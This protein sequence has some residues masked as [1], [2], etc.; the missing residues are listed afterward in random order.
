MIGDNKKHNITREDLLPTSR[1]NIWHKIIGV[2]RRK[3]PVIVLH[4]G[5]AAS[6]YY[7]EP[8]EALAEDR[9]VIFYDQL[10]CGK[11]DR[12]NDRA[13]WTIDYYVQEL[14]QIKK[15]LDLEKMHIIGHSWGTM[16]AVDYALSGQSGIS[17]LVLS[18]PCLS[19]K[20]WKIDQRKYIL[21]LPE[22]SRKIIE[23]TE[24]IGNFDSKEYQDV[25]MEYYKFHLCRLDVWPECLN[26]SF[27]EMNYGIY[28]YMWGA[29][30]FTVT[31]TLKNYDRTNDLGKIKAP[32]L[33]TCGEYDESSPQTCECYRKKIPG[34]ELIIF[35]DASHN[36]HLEKTQD[37]IKAV[38]D[39]LNR[40]DSY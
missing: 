24:R 4:G 14:S 3:T 22:E 20:M 36:H 1:G 32:V 27:N 30:E 16:I 15:I 34:S 37:Y 10:G 28:K 7:L 11:S 8:L 9:P 35:K 19:S 5:P 18:S 31:G 13:I 6:H 12:T 29:S 40:I 21:D 25:I 26:K 39:F 17:S 33:F 23:K 2:N 38:N